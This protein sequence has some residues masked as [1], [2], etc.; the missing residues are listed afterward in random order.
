MKTRITAAILL[1]A[2]CAANAHADG[3]APWTRRAPQAA[4]HPPFT[5]IHA[6]VPPTGF[7]PWA[8]TPRPTPGPAALA[9]GSHRSRFHGFGPWMSARA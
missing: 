1:I 3:F 8:A 5:L 2:Q 6:T 4:T 9:G 7:A